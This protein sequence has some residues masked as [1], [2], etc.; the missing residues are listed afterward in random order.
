MSS[1]PSPFTVWIDGD[2]CPK[3]IKEILFRA[4]ERRGVRTVLV[5]N[6]PVA[7]PKLAN[8]STVKVAQGLDVADAYLVKKAVAGDLV[9]TSDLPLA[10]E[11]VA[12]GVTAL[13]ARGE[14]YTAANVRER[15][16]LRDWAMEARESGIIAGGG[17]PPLNEKALRTFANAFDAWLSRAQKA[18]AAPKAP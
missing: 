11:L 13:S 15:L 5:A 12:K 3:P 2:G 10:A 17:P 9:I 14:A 4:A 18:T 8:L 7:V 16:S 6:H 1:P